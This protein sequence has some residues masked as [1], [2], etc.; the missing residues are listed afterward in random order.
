MSYLSTAADGSPI[1]VRPL[2]SDNYLRWCSSTRKYGQQHEVWMRQ[3]GH[4]YH[5][6]RF[7]S[8]RQMDLHHTSYANL[9]YEEAS[10]LVGVHFGRCHRQMEAQKTR[11]MTRDL[12]AHW[13]T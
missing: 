5:C 9:G 12:D 13:V 10:D 8:H 2:H 1:V 3:G 6:G 11:E 4:C 7:M